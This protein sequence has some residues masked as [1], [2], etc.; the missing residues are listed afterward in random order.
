MDNKKR[1]GFTLIELLATIAVLS[2]L[3]IVG[4]VAVFNVIDKSNEMSNEITF[5]TIKSSAINYVNEYNNKSDYWAPEKNG[6]ILTGNEFTCITIQQLI[7]KGFIKENPIDAEKKTA[8]DTDTIYKIKRDENYVVSSE[9]YEDSNE[10][11]CDRTKP[12][13]ES[14]TVYGPN[15]EV[16]SNTWYYDKS[17]S[18]QTKVK[19][20]YKASNSIKIDELKYYFRNEDLYTEPI[21]PAVEAIEIKENEI[22]LTTKLKAK[23]A[24]IDYFS[25]GKNVKACAK[26]K[27][28]NG[29]W[30]EEKCQTVNVDFSTP[31]K[32]EVK[33][34]NNEIKDCKDIVSTNWYKASTLKISGGGNSPSGNLYK[35]TIGS[36]TTNTDIQKKEP[37]IKNITVSAKYNIKTCNNVGICSD[38]KTIN[39]KID[40]KLPEIKND[41]IESGWK[42]E[43]YIKNI[44]FIDN[45][46]KLS[47]YQI[48][49]DKNTPDASKWTKIDGNKQEHTI[50]D[51]KVEKN[52]TIYIHVK[53]KAGNIAT[54]TIKVEKIDN[55]KPTC[56]AIKG[57]DKWTNENRT[58]A[59]TC[60]DNES[61]CK[62][63]TAGNYG[64][65]LYDKT[66]NI[67]T[68]SYEIEDNAGNKATCTHKDVKI[69]VDK[70]NPLITNF[71]LDTSYTNTLVNVSAT[72]KDEHSGIHSYKIS[73]N[74]N[75]GTWNELNDGTKTKDI[76]EEISSNG[77][78]YIW[79]K[80]VAGNLKQTDSIIVNNIDNKKPTISYTE[81][82][83]QPVSGIYTKKVNI[84]FTF[85]DNIEIKRYQ[86]KTSSTLGTWSNISGKNKHVVTKTTSQNLTYYVWVEDTAGNQTSTSV[87]V[88]Y[89][90]NTG[91]TYSSG[92]T[93]S[94]GSFTNATFND[95]QSGVD[96][97]KYL[98]TESSSQPNESLITNNKYTFSTTCGKKYYLWS[99]ATDKVGNVTIKNVSSKSSAACCDPGTYKYYTCTSEG[100]KRYRKYNNCTSSYDYETRYNEYCYYY[101][102]GSV[103]DCV[104]GLQPQYSNYWYGGTYTPIQ[105]GNIS[106]CDADSW[107]NWEYYECSDD[108]YAKSDKGYK[109]KERTNDCGESE[110]KLT[111][112]KCDTA[113]FDCY[114]KSCKNGV[115]E[116]KCYY[117]RGGDKKSY[118]K[119]DRSCSS[120]TDDE[121]DESNYEQ[122]K[123]LGNWVVYN[124][125]QYIMQ[126]DGSGITNLDNGNWLSSGTNTFYNILKTNVVGQINKGEIIYVETGNIK[127]NNYGTKFNI[128]YVEKSQID[129]DAYNACTAYDSVSDCADGKVEID[130][131]NYYK[132]YVVDYDSYYGQYSL[133]YV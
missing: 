12:I 33:I 109:V 79:V 53:D 17:S 8:I 24:S 7:N 110:Y 83:E 36:S 32:P 89:I 94:L 35:Y 123:T 76:E 84:T 124:T 55:V 108:G 86:I 13:I 26:A 126:G 60:Q 112:T 71:N 16:N 19:V 54:K 28:V 116:Y 44:K 5:S 93:L 82:K 75:S 42:K 70:D 81:N 90:D 121:P 120:S 80:D 21:T 73:T 67:Y 34:C 118:I 30:S 107:S 114:W 56:P 4:G 51:Y 77:T 40:N 129:E 18:E 45:E 11:F 130:G 27:N 48:T 41:A 25:F 119:K 132:I 57:F 47:E 64:S 88:N 52:S 97:V 58:I 59:Y 98:V 95:S 22:I 6:N 61:G 65:K 131:S 133:G 111:S 103:G 29:V 74:V 91:P 101:I 50:E 46:S 43:K 66:T 113:D 68:I 63:N 127:S 3:L 92:G 99:K 10:E 105:T 62:K 72:I 14:I 31:T 78:Y 49:V 104:N 106:C 96:S 23:N 37:Y 69:L 20:K 100:Y 87:V 15:E 2:L 85:E 115:Q 117:Y 1:K 102:G 38:Y 128:I 9:I 122:R 125:D 39:V